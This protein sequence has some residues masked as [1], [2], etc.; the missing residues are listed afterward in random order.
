MPF[1][2]SAEESPAPV[3]H[4]RALGDPADHQPCGDRALAPGLRK[5][6]TEPTMEEEVAASNQTYESAP[7]LSGEPD[8]PRATPTWHRVFPGE[9]CQLSVMRRWLESLLPPCPQ[10]DDL[11]IVANELATNA[12][13]HTAA[14][15]HGGSFEVTI[16]RGQ[17]T[18]RIAVTDPG[19]PGE[20]RVIYEPDAEHGRGLQV[21]TGL[22]IRTGVCGGQQGRQVW[23][24]IAWDEAAIMELR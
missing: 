14:S 18:V 19:A 22:S 11:S 12:V 1:R 6:P 23:A 3:S 21:V 10:R 15:G 4:V 17:R 24:D 20:P 5:H 7:D 8:V 13:L 9:K 2:S 16:V